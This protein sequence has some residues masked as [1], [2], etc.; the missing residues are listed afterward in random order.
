MSI[1]I[2]KDTLSS[3]D[4]QNILHHTKKIKLWETELGICKK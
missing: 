2:L 4:K 1:G 3:L